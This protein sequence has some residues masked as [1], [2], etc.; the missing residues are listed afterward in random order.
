MYSEKERT[1][2][3]FSHFKIISGGKW[4]S[5]FTSL[6]ILLSIKNILYTTSSFN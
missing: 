6:N 5:V 4:M 1:I 3:V 2:F